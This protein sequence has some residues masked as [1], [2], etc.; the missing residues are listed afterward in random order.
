MKLRSVKINKPKTIINI[1]KWR[2][3]K[4]LFSFALIIIY[5]FDKY[6]HLFFKLLKNFGKNI[7]INKSLKDKNEKFEVDESNP[8]NIQKYILDN[9]KQRLKGPQ[10]MNIKF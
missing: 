9:I 4:Y 3:L 5:L 6:S 2:I 1:K 8:E 10:L 7:P